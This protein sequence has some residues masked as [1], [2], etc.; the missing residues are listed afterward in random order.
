MD[1][2]KRVVTLNIRSPALEAEAWGNAAREATYL[3]IFAEAIQYRDALII[4]LASALEHAQ[5]YAA[6]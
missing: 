1:Q 3:T 4:V 5:C 6:V 2:L